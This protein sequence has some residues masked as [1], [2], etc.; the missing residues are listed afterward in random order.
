[1][2]EGAVMG[3]ADYVAPEQVM[4]AHAADSRADLYSLG[5]TFYFLLTGQPP[6]PNGTVTERVIEHQTTLPPDI[7]TRRGEVPAELALLCHRL[8]AKKP[9]QRIQTA[10]EV[11]V[12]LS[13]WLQRY[14]AAT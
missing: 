3:S 13:D 12:A 5:C 10:A 9:E 14:E 7:R 1:T 4:N 11:I 6:F 8:L 2:Q